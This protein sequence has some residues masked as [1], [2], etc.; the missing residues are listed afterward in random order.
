MNTTNT[1]LKY[2]AYKALC[3]QA[4]LAEKEIAPYSMWLRCADWLVMYG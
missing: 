3:Q 4:G 1:Y 2:I